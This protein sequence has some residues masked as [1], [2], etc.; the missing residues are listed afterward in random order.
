[1]ALMIAVIAGPFALTSDFTGGE[2]EAK[3]RT[4]QETLWHA[5]VAA[6]LFSCHCLR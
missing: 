4:S 2:H 1:M 3:N 5:R 6:S